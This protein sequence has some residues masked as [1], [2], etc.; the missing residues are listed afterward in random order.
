M[1]I[2]LNWTRGR[3]LGLA[4][5]FLSI[6]GLTQVVIIAIAQYGMKIGS[7]YLVIFIPIGVTLALFY[8]VIIYMESRTTIAKYRETRPFIQKKAKQLPFAQR[9]N[10]DLIRPVLVIVITFAILFG[11]TVAVTQKLD[12]HVSFVIAENVGAIGAIILASYV[13]ADARRK[14]R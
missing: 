14:T 9:I 2:K 7:R 12:P 1:P 5:I 8:S 10:L 3:N 6:I 4:L 11:L 13:E